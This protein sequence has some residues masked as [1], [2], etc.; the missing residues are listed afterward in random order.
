MNEILNQLKKARREKKLS[1]AALGSKLGF[2]Q[3]HISSIEAGLT[4]PR[5]SSVMD[6]ARFLDYEVM[7]IPKSFAPA[8]AALIR[9]EDIR[10]KPAWQPNGDDT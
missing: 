3:S 8:I 1:Q 10:N 2:P 9:G 7:L 5:L 6:L 4:N